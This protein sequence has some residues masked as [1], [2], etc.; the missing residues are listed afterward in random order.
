M[1][2][3]SQAQ[4]H[5]VGQYIEG[6]EISDRK[7]EAGNGADTVPREQVAGEN[8]GIV[9]DSDAMT[10]GATDHAAPDDDAM[11]RMGR[12]TSKGTSDDPMWE[13]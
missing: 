4:H 10:S 11:R 12:A 3:D 9:G 5:D 13:D 7:R 8:A 6:S 2:H 1:Q